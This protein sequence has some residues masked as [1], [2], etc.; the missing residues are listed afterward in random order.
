MNTHVHKSHLAN[1]LHVILKPKLT[2]F[3]VMFKEVDINDYL[4][5][6][7]AGTAWCCHH[8]ARFNGTIYKT[9]IYKNI[10]FNVTS[11]KIFGTIYWS[12]SD[13]VHYCGQKQR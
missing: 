6:Y 1:S 2:F 11:L 12:S 3:I 7:S 8:L 13:A 9:C 10:N 5:W 4:K